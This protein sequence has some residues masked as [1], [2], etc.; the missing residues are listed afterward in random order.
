M[1]QP[2]WGKI[3]QIDNNNLQKQR[4][5][6]LKFKRLNIRQDKNTKIVEHYK[7]KSKPQNSTNNESKSQF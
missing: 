6:L 7:M 1:R 2:R 4:K 3:F 5:F